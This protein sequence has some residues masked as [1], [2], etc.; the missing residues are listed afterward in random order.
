MAGHV[1]IGTIKPRMVLYV[2]TDS[3]HS[4]PIRIDDI[5]FMTRANES[6]VCLTHKCKRKTFERLESYSFVDQTLEITLAGTG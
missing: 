5:A 4:T 6:L 1:V 3:G 2:P